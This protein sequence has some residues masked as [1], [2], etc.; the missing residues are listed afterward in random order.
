[1][2]LPNLLTLRGKLLLAFLGVA[3]FPLLLVTLVNQQS[4][5]K[6]LT[7]SANKTLLSAASQTASSIDTFIKTNLGI[8]R[9][10]AQLPIL[11]EFL[12]LPPEQQ[13]AL[14]GEV[15]ATLRSLSRK[16]T[17][18][19]SSYALINYAGQNVLDTY[20]PYIDQ[21]ESKQ[22]YVQ[23]P[24]KTG[25]PYASPILFPSDSSVASMF[26]SSPVRN[27]TGDI[28]GV[29]RVRYSVAAIQRLV[30]QSTNLSGN[31]NSFA[32]LLD[33]NYIRIAQGSVNA[34]ELAFK[35]VVPLAPTQIQALQAKAR[36][37]RGDASEFST[38]LPAFEQGLD[39]IAQ[40]SYFMTELVANEDELNA[41]A[42]VKLSSQPWFVVFV[43]P[44]ST[45]LEPIKAQVRNTLLLSIGLTGAVVAVAV[46]VSQ[47][48]SKPLTS[49]AGTVTQFT[50]G[51]LN[52]RSS[53][54]SEDE[55]GVLAQSFN[56]MAE[57]VGKLLHGLE[58]R[59]QELEVSQHVTVSV[60]ELSKAIL[61]PKLLL[62]EA[63][64]LLK[65]RF[66]LHEVQIYLLDSAT[67]QLSQPVDSLAS[68]FQPNSQPN[69]P[70]AIS[71]NCDQ[72]LV[73]R[74]ARTQE[75]LWV[76]HAACFAAS[77]EE[78]CP[79][80]RFEVAIPLIARNSLLGVL[81]I[82]NQ[83]SQPFSETDLDTFNTLAGQIATAL[84]NACL[85]EEVQKAE[86]QYRD[87]AQELE[88][89]LREL[90][91]TQTQLVQSEK[92]SSLGQLVAGIAHE[93]NN[94]VNFIFGNLTHAEAYTNELI[95]LLQLYQQHYPEPAADIQTEAE[96][97][98]LDF[99]LEDLPKLLKS[100]KVGAERIQ[101]IVLS[102]RN[103]SRMDEAE[104]KDVDIHEGIDSTLI[105]LQNRLKAK[106]GQCAIEIIKEY[107]TLPLVEC[108]VGQLNQVF[109]NLLTNAL[110]ALEEHLDRQPANSPEKMTGVI[111]ICT[112][113]LNS[114]QIRISIADNGPGIPEE[115]QRRL[116]D[117]FFTTKPVGKG[118]GL[119]LSISYQIVTEK[120]GGSL[121]CI[122]VPGQGTEFVIEIPTQQRPKAV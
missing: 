98:D 97:I 82:Q 32:I 17:L 72:S 30:S 78:T 113:L 61:D 2:K 44:Q 51:H 103:F 37:P 75:M 62:Q 67:S 110:D 68:S 19:I 15:E 41:A 88:Q 46:A 6:E 53:I 89:T 94:P 50:A 83:Q 12:S 69:S 104:M 87:K 55:I 114:K 47:L 107:N 80:I 54:Q 11:A 109:M 92:M 16:D 84:Q 79:L 119:G 70:T 101:K 63:I 8:V 115:I 1:M 99:L 10:E 95:D 121:Q 64:A 36:L 38:H 33:E 43:Q 24:V 42:A 85:F 100:M 13:Q 90:Q 40:S 74:T 96:A 34:S 77:D 49:L 52:A 20:T 7:H 57:Q 122:S 117:P 102:L 4:T 111:R 76:D 35:S 25:L 58:Q 18:N 45:F 3:F 93:I 48:L 112:Q 86:A 21:D 26:F 56:A 31:E 60:G 81:D 29:L 108:Y 65:S 105:I 5:Q 73:A 39:R 14:A 22:D 9:V 66:G 91:A 59:T 106:P 71:L 120:H 28:I 116:F 27:A 118:T 23:K